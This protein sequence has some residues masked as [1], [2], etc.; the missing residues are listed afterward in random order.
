MVETPRYKLLQQQLI[1]EVDEKLKIDLL[2]EL[3]SEVR[4][5]DLEEAT[6]IADEVIQRSRIVAYNNGIG[7][8][9]KL[10][11]SCQWLKGEYESAI[12][13]LKVGLNIATK[14]KNK[15]LEG[16]ILYYL[17]NIYRDKGEFAQV[18]TNYKNALLIYETIG[19]DFAQS[20]IQASISN[21]L[22]DLGDFE[23]ALDYALKCLPVFE[24]VKNTS[25][26][27]QVCNTLGNIYFKKDQ[28]GEAMQYFKR[29]LEN[30]EFETLAHI[31]AESGMGKVYYKMLDYEN[32]RNFL[33][34]ALRQAEHVGNIEVQIICHFYLGR[35]YMDKNSFRQA[36]QYLNYAF[37]L[38]GDFSRK[39]D[40]M[41]IHEMLSALYDKT[42][43]IPKAF[44]HLKSFEQLKDEIFQQKIITE[45][46]NLQVKQQI[47]LAQKEKEVAER[48]AYLK[49]Q[50]MANMS[51][52]IRTP[53]NAI[54]GMTNLLLSKEHLPAQVRY[55][56]A[57]ELSA[58]NLL[59]II[60]DILDV[61][62]IEAGKIVIEH[63]DF[64]LD[65]VLQG[66]K[67]ML[68]LKAEEKNIQF[69]ISRD[70]NIP[71]RL[72]GDPTRLNQVLINLAG[73]AVKFTERGF[74]ELKSTLIK[75]DAKLHLQF[76]IID[77]G[78]GI[79][80]EHIDHIFES[81]TQA[82]TDVTRKF[83][84]TGLGLTISRQITLL[85]GGDISVRSIP[86]KGTV[87]T[88]VIPFDEAAAQEEAKK[89]LSLGK[90][91]IAMLNNLTI[92]LAEDNKFNQIVATETL[93]ERLPRVKLD[94]AEN[95]REAIDKLLQ[96][97]Y[98]LVLMDVQMPVMDGVVATKKIR[99]EL[100]E[101]I[102]GVK[103][104][105]M[106]ANVLEEDVNGYFEIGID[107]YIAK[108][109]NVHDLLRKMSRVLGENYQPVNELALEVNDSQEQPE[110][111]VAVHPKVKTV[112][113]QRPFAGRAG[114]KTHG[115]KSF[116]HPA[117]HAHPVA[118]TPTQRTQL[119]QTQEPVVAIAESVKLPE[120]VANME[121]TAA[122]VPAV[123]TGRKI[124]DIVTD[125]NFL[126][127]FT[128]GN[129][130]KMR[131][132]IGVFLDNAP[133]LLKSLEKSLMEK[134]YPA[135]KIAAHSLKPQMSYMGIKEEVSHIYQLEQMAGNSPEFEVLK[136][137]LSDL[138]N[139][140]EKA[141]EELK[142][143]LK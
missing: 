84:G 76:E 134:D 92:L 24:Q 56:K 72:T 18:I 115:K 100:P 42:G 74:V 57:I 109:F 29:N 50:F 48:T 118:V 79:A 110:P 68:L 2:A 83:G 136:N 87:F 3:G 33:T 35:L 44:F 125:R 99:E 19:D 143:Y 9:L 54:V 53:M 112:E 138:E 23:S 121:A 6:K 49:Q 95:G 104:I 43:D 120:P 93:L 90:N 108:P 139:V 14:I 10:L 114:G 22:Y 89:E 13:T 132:Y 88:I 80:P 64:T 21:L 12:E 113:R 69:K 34:N 7:N 47:E 122:P 107:E 17:G 131:K 30:T 133:G 78:I 101:P 86:G 5:F 67:D 36:L 38:A 61:S 82:G 102:R 15:R 46:R 117:I 1:H 25:N 4:N 127:Q 111:Y 94:I 41:S 119:R 26:L 140:C 58:N 52:E 40:L 39:H 8:G 55:L 129:I 128:G 124:P 91:E 63:V 126:N 45:L 98:D 116:Y 106:T 105:A 130:D 28:Y 66:V 135:M 59:V 96:N 103:I 32:A 20:I 123:N 77:T 73:N 51:H 81:F 16:R 31:T 75:R 141:F 70:S 85:M 137:E 142:T 11:G 37:V 62:K 65:E 60:N 71:K 97:A 27:I